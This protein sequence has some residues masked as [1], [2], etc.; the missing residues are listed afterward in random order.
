MERIPKKIFQT[1]ENKKFD[2]TFQAIVNRWREK[3]PDYEYFLYNDQECSNFIRENYPEKVFNAYKR[4]RP[5]AFKADL[6]RYCILYTYG[7]VYVDIDTLAE[8]KLDIL[9]NDCA[10]DFCVPIDLNINKKEGE[11]NLF[12]T[13]ICT[14]PQNPI[15]LTCIE[16]IVYYVEN[17]IIPKNPL[18]F[19]GPGVLGRAVNIFL[20]RP[21]E[22]SFVGKE[23][24]YNN[25]LFLK[26]HPS[27]EHVT[28]PTGE[29]LFQ[30]KNG[31]QYLN[32]LYKN[33]CKKLTNYISWV[34]NSPF[35]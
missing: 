24:I 15:L 11:H 29:I 7:G 35:V 14:K 22:S 3:N 8:D 4:I 32:T 6:W 28:T 10:I 23:G 27:I 26:F 33:E 21:E 5:G 34:N 20:N 12:N 30:N 19:S 2:K 17:N 31:N 25:I 1:W 18:D 13:F 9:L 16:K